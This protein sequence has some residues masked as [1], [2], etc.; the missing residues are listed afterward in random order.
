MMNILIIGL[1]SIAKKHLHALKELGI[2]AQIYAL[3]SMP[4]ADSYQEVINVYDLDTLNVSIDF[5]IISTPTNQHGRYIRE[6]AQKCIPTLIEK[7]PLHDL[8]EAETIANLIENTSTITYVACNLRFHPCIRFLQ[9]FFSIEQ[10]RVNEVNVYC[11][12]YLPA[13]R[14]G[15]DYRENYSAIAAQGGG[16]HLD[17][18]HELDYTQW[19]FGLPDK[20]HAWRR[21]S[22]SL[23]IDAYDYANY[24]FEYPGFTASIVLNY[25]RRDPKRTIEIVFDDQT[26]TVDLLANQISS[27]TA[28]VLFEAPEF[29]VAETYKHQMEYFLKMLQDNR[30][31]MN[32]FAESLKTLKISLYDEKVTE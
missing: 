24:L 32:T 25:Y 15:Q 31:P 23:G 6:M 12:S 14:P 13:W 8:H 11:G 26:W 19:I 20:V 5:A 29:R 3:R 10:T 27:S 9:N 18:F 30:L 28:G 16:V 1:G 4:N 21:S 2:P 17:L 7:P 22:S